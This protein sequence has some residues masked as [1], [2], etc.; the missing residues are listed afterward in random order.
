[1]PKSGCRWLGIALAA[2][3]ALFVGVPEVQ[4]GDDK[5]WRK[6]RHHYHHHHHYGR[7]YAKPP[8]VRY[9]APPVYY[10]PPPVMYAPPVYYAPPP[11]LS[12]GINVPLG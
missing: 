5:G 12:L 3:A 8:K 2:G 10:V 11:G 6:H 7:Y 1:M 4:A 9:Y